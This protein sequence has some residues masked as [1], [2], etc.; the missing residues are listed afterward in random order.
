[1][2]EIGRS[3][4]LDDIHIQ[5]GGDGRTVEA[6]AAVFDT[7]AEIRDQH[8][9]YME[10]IDRAAFNRTLSHGIG[11]V[12]VHFNHGYNLHGPDALAAVPIGK[13]LSIDPDGRGL[14][15]VTRFNHTALADSAL[16]AIRAGDIGGYSFRGRIFRSTPDR[17]PR[18]RAGDSLPTVTRTELG[19]SEYG[20]TPHPA[21]EAAG[22]LAVRSADALAVE[23]ARLDGDERAELIR[24]LSATPGGV[25]ADD[26][27]TP[28]G[29]GPGAEDPPAGHSGRLA[30]RRALLRTRLI[31]KGVRRG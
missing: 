21:Y 22:I 3:F 8:G 29:S 18:R 13:P 28:D 26:T 19:L 16:E 10:V 9:H 14:R 17:L 4:A 11:K 25:P 5:R 27:T 7:P 20:P 6:Y 23:L 1:M 31:E 2:S 15:T 30:I 12:R 24:L